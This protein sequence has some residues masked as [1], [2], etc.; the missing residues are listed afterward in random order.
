LGE[1][2]KHNSWHLQALG[3]DPDYQRQGAAALLVNKVAEKAAPTKTLL[4]VEC[5]TETNV[6]LT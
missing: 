6:K 3:V 2:T 4:C 1:G 5:S